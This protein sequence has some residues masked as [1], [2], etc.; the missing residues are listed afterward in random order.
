MIVGNGLGFEL[1]D[2]SL[3]LC[4]SQFHAYSF[5][6]VSSCCNA[7]AAGHALHA[8][9]PLRWSTPVDVSRCKPTLAHFWANSGPVTS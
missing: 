6:L 3:D 5:Q 4:G 9:P 1:V 7:K 8:L 2:R